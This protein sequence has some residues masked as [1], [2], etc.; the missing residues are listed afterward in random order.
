[1][2]HFVGLIQKD[3]T[4]GFWVKAF[5][6]QYI[7]WWKNPLTD[8][9][10]HFFSGVS[11]L[12]PLCADFPDKSK[13]VTFIKLGQVIIFIWI[14]NNCCHFGWRIV[15][16]AHLLCQL[17]IYLGKSWGLNINIKSKQKSSSLIISIYVL[18]VFQHHIISF[19]FIH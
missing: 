16:N 13:L 14:L 4:L 5:Q 3:P 7:F 1:M 8:C 15:S 9:R 12:R 17:N 19:W 6:N 11:P 10:R 2:H 18:V